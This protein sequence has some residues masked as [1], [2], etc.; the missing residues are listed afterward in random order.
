MSF[1][2]IL[3]IVYIFLFI[4]DIAALYIGVKCHEWAMFVIVTLF[5]IAITVTFACLWIKCPM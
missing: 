1:T 5:I 3:T 4:T 2:A